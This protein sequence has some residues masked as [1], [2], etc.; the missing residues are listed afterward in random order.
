[1]I[2]VTGQRLSLRMHRFLPVSDSARGDYRSGQLSSNVIVRWT[3]EVAF[4][5]QS[6]MSSACQLDLQYFPF[7]VHDCHL[8]FVSWTYDVQ[9]VSVLFFPFLFV[10]TLPQLVKMLV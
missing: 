9:Q 2:G 1:M 5:V 4:P 8:H 7:D 3:G 6:V 10:E